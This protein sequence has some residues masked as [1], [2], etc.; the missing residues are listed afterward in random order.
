M[1]NNAILHA[2]KLIESGMNRDTWSQ[3]GFNYELRCTSLDFYC[4][5][6]KPWGGVRYITVAYYNRYG[7]GIAVNYADCA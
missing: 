2:Q 5:F 3:Y 1:H 7:T 6:A 4:L